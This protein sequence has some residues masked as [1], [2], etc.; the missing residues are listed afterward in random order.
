MEPTVYLLES[1]TLHPLIHDV[2][3]EVVVG[4]EPWL[5]GTHDYQVKDTRPIS[6]GTGARVGHMNQETDDSA[7]C[8]NGYKEQVTFDLWY[9]HS[10][11]HSKMT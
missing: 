8:P 6:M 11:Q 7:C 5:G 1:C 9:R 3:G 4:Q 2:Q 10:A